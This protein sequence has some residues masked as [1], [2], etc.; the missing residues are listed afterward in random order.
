MR[1]GARGSGLEENP[2]SVNREAGGGRGGGGG[3]FVPGRGGYYRGGAHGPGGG[4]LG[5]SGGRPD[6]AQG[7]HMVPVVPFKPAPEFEMKGND[8]PALPGLDEPQKV[9][10]SNDSSKPWDSK[11]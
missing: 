9:S 4:A 8:F 5:P 2:G 10:E 7:D 6:L 3:A 1:G 11:G